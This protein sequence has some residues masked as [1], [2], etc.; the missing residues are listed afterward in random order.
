M[1]HKVGWLLL[2]CIH[3]STFHLN[4]WTC[5][6]LSVVNHHWRF[7]LSNKSLCSHCCASLVSCAGDRKK[8]DL[9][10]TSYSIVSQRDTYRDYLWWRSV[11][12]DFCRWWWR[13]STLPLLP[14]SF[15]AS[16]LT[17]SC[18]KSQIHKIPLHAELHITSPWRAKLL[19]IFLFT[20]RN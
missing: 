1:L 4:S 3:L 8:S 9:F 6:F 19:K 20:I 11:R 17:L 5:E 18:C 16:N 13:V 2:I 14:E 12:C 7:I 10:Q 15:L